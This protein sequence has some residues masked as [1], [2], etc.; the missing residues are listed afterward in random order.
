MKI[1]FRKVWNII[2]IRFCFLLFGLGGIVVGLV[3]APIVRWCT[4]NREKKDLNVQYAISIAF[5]LLLF[6]IETFRIAKF[7]FKNFERL[8]SDK[9][10]LIIANHPTF[11]DY[12]VIVSQLKHCYTMTKGAVAK[13]FFMRWTTG[14]AGYVSNA[15]AEQVLPKIE[16]VLGKGQN[17]LIFPEGTRTTM[18]QPIKLQRGVANLAL[19]LGAD[20]R[21]L[22]INCA[23]FFLTKEDKWYNPPG[24]KVQFTVEVG[25]L[26]AIQPW[27]PK[28]NMYAIPARRLTEYLISKLEG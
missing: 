25:E 14:N 13:N 15:E 4:F 17:L 27:L 24:A 6:A 10:C 3:I 28:D 5:R 9:G 22:H 19:R 20:I 1:L 11:I 21:I 26:V 2:A 8:N 7:S 23:P 18:G 12:V 16:A